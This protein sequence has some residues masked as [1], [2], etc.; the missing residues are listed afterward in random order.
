MRRAAAKARLMTLA[1]RIRE[2]RR[3]YPADLFDIIVDEAGTFIGV[4]PRRM[5]ALFRRPSDRQGQDDK[6]A[7]GLPRL[8][9]I[10]LGAWRRRQLT[11]RG[12]A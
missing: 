3:T 7:A 8:H 10:A 2:I 5:S 11:G 12:Q 9:R 4:A 1:E 6:R